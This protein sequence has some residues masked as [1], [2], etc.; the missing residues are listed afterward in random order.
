V[1]NTAAIVTA[2]V[3]SLGLALN[4]SAQ[5]RPSTEPGTQTRPSTGTSTRTE[6]Q[7]WA[8]QSGAMEASRIIGTK[9]KNDQ[10]RD[11]GEIDQLIVNPS[12]GQVTHLVLGGGGVLGVGEQKVVVQWDDVRFQPDPNNRDRMVA[13]IEQSK[14]DAA[15][16]YEARRDRDTPPAASP[17]TSPSPRTTPRN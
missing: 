14:I 2:S 13:M 16:R 15:P 4:V 1:K 7:A 12:D 17:S 11:V 3:L 9:I 8:P 10:G 5:M 6:R